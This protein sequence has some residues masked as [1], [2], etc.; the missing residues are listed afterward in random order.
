MHTEWTW[1]HDGVLKRKRQRTTKE[2]V[3]YKEHAILKQPF[4]ALAPARIKIFF[5][6]NPEQIPFF[7]AAPC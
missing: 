5:L 4:R 2:G 1:W 6:E 3:L 7:C